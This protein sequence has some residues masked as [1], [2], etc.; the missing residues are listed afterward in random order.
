MTWENGQGGYVGYYSLR[1]VFDGVSCTR[2][3]SHWVFNLEFV[4]VQ[5]V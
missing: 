2:R 4:K 1:L 3:L 5:Y